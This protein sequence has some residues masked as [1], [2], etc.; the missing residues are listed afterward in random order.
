M[1][2]ASLCCCSPFSGERR[3][4]DMEEWIGKLGGADGLKVRVTA[5]DLADHPRWDPASP[6]VCDRLTEAIEPGLVDIIICGPPCS[7]RSGARWI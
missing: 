1:T 7:T 2:I 3:D 6:R 4:G 5:A